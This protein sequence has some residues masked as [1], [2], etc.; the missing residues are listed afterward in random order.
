MRKV[1]FIILFL[2]AGALFAETREQLVRYLPRNSHLAGGADFLQMQENEV[3]QSME[4]NGQIWSYDDKNGIIE[5]IRLLK[6][7]TKKDLNAFAFSKYVNNYGGSGEVR[8]FLLKRDWSQDV[9]AFPATPYAGTSLYRISPEQDK[10][11]VLLTANTI[12]VGNLNEV[13]MAVDVSAGKVPAIKENPNLAPLYAKIPAGSTVW[14]VAMP[15]SRRKAADANAKQSTN[16]MIGG[17]K[18]YYF[19]GIPTKTATRAQFYGQTEDE[20]QAAFMS[21]FM[22]GTLLVTKFRVEQ[23]LAEMLDKIDVKHNGNTVNVTMVVTK[24]MVDAYFKG[25]LGF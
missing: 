14:A 2:L 6:L 19:Y 22:I 10:Y 23:P 18:T 3:Y 21:S 12:A 24:E 16:A 1:I 17:F 9:A 11:A 13:K 5:Y 20:K 4:R 7:D 25:K 15:L 8:V